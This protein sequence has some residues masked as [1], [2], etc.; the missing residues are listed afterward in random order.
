[1]SYKFSISLIA[2]LFAVLSSAVA[3][4]ALTEDQVRRYA[5]ALP[6]LSA[7]GEE[8]EKAGVEG[9]SDDY[10]IIENGEFAPY[11]APLAR[12][13]K[14]HPGEYKKVNVVAK[15]H[16]FANAA[17]MAL[18]ADR[19]MLA[20]MA[21]KMPPEAA[22]MASAMTPEMLKMLPPETQAQYKTGMA[23]MKAAENAPQ[24]DKDVVSPLTPLLDEAM[25]E[26]GE[27]AGAFSSMGGAPG[28]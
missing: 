14:E 20:Y 13:K 9:F 27:E 7:L 23:M 15:K 3:A 21:L 1:M 4:D 19:T 11:T 16:K 2:V 10:E 26:A 8:M 17:E 18:V 6:D 12:L 24:A 25:A 28:R 5:A 22:A